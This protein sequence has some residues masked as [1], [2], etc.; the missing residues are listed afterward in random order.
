MNGPKLNRSNLHMYIYIYTYICDGDDGERE[1][2]T[3]VSGEVLDIT[4]KRLAR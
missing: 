1:Y 3:S 4:G 2:K